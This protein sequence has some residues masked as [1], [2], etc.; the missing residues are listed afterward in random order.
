MAI[1]AGCL[2]VLVAALGLS[3][4]GDSGSDDS[5]PKTFEQDGYPFT[6]EYPASFESSNDVTTATQLGSSADATTAVGID[7]SNGIVIQKF[8]L[9]AT[10]TESNLDAVKRQADALI[11][12][13]DPGASGKPAQTGGF[14]SLTYA[15]FPLQSPSGGQSRVTLLFDGR[16]EYFINCQSTPQEREAINAACDQ[17][18]STLK[19]V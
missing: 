9:G 7:D 11:G 1:G 12:S 13:A 14:P 15:A 2:A 4:C 10:V 6:F 8:S 3:A 5:G 19:Q 17:A 18:L 16:D